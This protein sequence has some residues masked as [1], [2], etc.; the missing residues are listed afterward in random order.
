[1]YTAITPIDIRKESTADHVFRVIR[2]KIV[3]MDLKPHQQISRTEL[4]KAFGVSQ[5]PVR[6][7]ILRLEEIGLV[8]VI[9]QSKTE[10]AP[11]DS[12]RITETQF[13]RRALEIEVCLTAAD[14]ITQDELSVIQDRITQQEALVNDV[15]DQESLH[16]LILDRSVHLDRLRRL[17]LPLKGK[18]ERIIAEHKR[19]FE[20]VVSRE[21]RLIVE[22]IH[23]HLPAVPWALEE[24]RAAHPDYFV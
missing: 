13:L 8:N 4:A 17:Q 21:Y 6:E 15:A 1:M 24:L 11:I 3:S 10:I 19:I 9:P 23:T 12:R 16:D 20:A 14:R 2:E 5:T 18:R 7:A 22:A